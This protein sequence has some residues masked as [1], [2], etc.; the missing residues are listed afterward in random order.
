MPPP[1]LFL[2]IFFGLGLW[3]GL[4]GN[5]EWGLV[6][7]VLVGAALLHRR[8]PLGAALGIMLVAGAPRGAAPVAG[9][10]GAGGGGRARSGAPLGGAN[11]ARRVQAFGRTNWELMRWSCSSP[12]RC[13]VAAESPKE[14]R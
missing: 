13:L 2:T 1:I 11:K 6:L 14:S 9:Q 5:G 8:A 10:G 7:P 12:T 3:A 4:S